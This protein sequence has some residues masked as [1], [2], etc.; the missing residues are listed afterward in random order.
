MS[1]YN[2]DNTKNGKSYK[3]ENR[4]WVSYRFEIS[5]ADFGLNLETVSAS[6]FSWIV[7]NGGWK[8]HHSFIL[9]LIMRKKKKKKKNTI[10]P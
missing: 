2:H 5:K 6:N 7:K 3:T 1:D 9:T 4:T 10:L 8:R